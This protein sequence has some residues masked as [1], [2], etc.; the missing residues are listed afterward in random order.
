MHRAK[1]NIR[2]CLAKAGIKLSYD[3]FARQRLIQGLPGYGPDLTD[4]AIDAIWIG[5]ERAYRVRFARE[6]LHAVVRVE[7]NVNT[8][9]SAV[10]QLT[11]RGSSEDGRAAAGQMARHICGARQNTELIQQFGRSD[12]DRS[13]SARASAWREVRH[14]CL[15][16]KG[17]RGSGTSQ[18]CSRRWRSAEWF[19]DDAPLNAEPRETIE[20]LRGKWIVEAADLAAVST[21]PIRIRLQGRSWRGRHE[22]A[23]ATMGSTRRERTLKRRRFGGIFVEHDQQLRILAEPRLRQPLSLY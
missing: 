13:G 23:R 5:F 21:Q 6:H 1:A 16:S 14:T 2:R 9:H 8:F 15:C 18:P 19:S 4:G 11:S 12:P 10:C 3:A 22:K 7:A 17:A 20:R